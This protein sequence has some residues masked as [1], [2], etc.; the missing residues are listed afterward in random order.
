MG[1]TINV[2]E[3]EQ[4]TQNK[5]TA[6]GHRELLALLMR[7]V[8][9]IKTIEGCNK[10]GDMSFSINVEDIGL[11][12]EDFYRFN[13]ELS[14]R[15]VIDCLGELLIRENL[16]K[17]VPFLVA[18]NH[19]HYAVAVAKSHHHNF[20]MW[21]KKENML[22]SFHISFLQKLLTEDFSMA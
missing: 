11:S 7:S 4:K 17:F 13:K 2:N 15:L 12:A 9:P 22:F 6:S 21:I 1:D 8:P 19:E 3:L 18:M 16:A 20:G 5:R 10:H 14:S